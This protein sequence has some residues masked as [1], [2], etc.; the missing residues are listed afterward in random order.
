LRNQD[1]RYEYL[2]E[3]KQ[4]EQYSEERYQDL[5]EDEEREYSENEYGEENNEPQYVY[6]WIDEQGIEHYTNNIK[7]VPEEYR[8]TVIE[9]EVW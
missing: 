9:L 7:K 3:N 6:K 8:D 4:D 5:N 1:S 2:D